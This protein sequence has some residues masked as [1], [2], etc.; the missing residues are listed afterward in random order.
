VVQAIVVP[1]SAFEGDLGYDLVAGTL[2]EPQTLI[3]ARDAMRIVARHPAP[4]S[5]T[6]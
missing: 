6:P 2:G 3:L 5:R 1:Q 4:P